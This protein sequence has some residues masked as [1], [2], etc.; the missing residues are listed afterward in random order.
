MEEKSLKAQ[1]GHLEGR[2]RKAAASGD[3]MRAQAEI[4]KL[5]INVEKLKAEMHSGTPAWEKTKLAR[6]EQRPYTLDYIERIFDGFTE[7]H[8][9][10][11]FADDPAIVAG[12][13]FFQGNQVMVIG[14]QKGRDL[15]QRLQRNYGMAQP[16]GYRKALR[17]MKV[18]EKF[19]RP[20][21]TFVDTPGAYPGIGAEERGIAEAIAYNLREM[22]RLRVPLIVTII[23][24]GGSGGA[25]GIAV[26]DRVLM[27]ENAIYSVI[28]PE[29]CSAILWRDQEHAEQ[30]AEALRLTADSLLD[31]RIVD[32]IVPEPPGGAHMDYDAMAKVLS[33]RLA[34]ALEELLAIDIDE[35]IRRRY[36]KFRRMGEFEE[37]LLSL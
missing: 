24:E 25:L 17:L 11:R 20:V 10:R 30:A 12:I 6:H 19:N 8:G 5:R 15:K 9:D 2:L 18:A 4:E 36:L 7:L 26:G 32:E 33:G 34:M 13:A 21:F 3:G 37:A 14:H 35:L 27:L 28:S 1:L 22:A 16:E 31:F 23:G 29:S